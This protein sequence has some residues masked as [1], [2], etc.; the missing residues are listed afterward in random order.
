[1]PLIQAYLAQL[2]IH[3]VLRAQV[4]GAL[5]TSHQL[6]S[7]VISEAQATHQVANSL[8]HSMEEA[9]Q[10][11]LNVLSRVGQAIDS[12]D[13]LEKEVLEERMRRLEQASVSSR[14]M[15]SEQRRLERLGGKA[16]DLGIRIRIVAMNTSIEAMRAAS[17][18]NSAIGVLAREIGNLAI[19]VQ[20]LGLELS[21]SVQTLSQHLHREL[22]EGMA[23][24][25]QAIED[26][27]T[28][29]A[30]QVAA[31]RVSH[32]ELRQF[33]ES[34][35][36]Q[37]ADTGRQVTTHAYNTLGGVQN[38]DILRQ[39]LEQVV[40]VLVRMSEHDL[41]LRQA[42]RGEAALP[43]EWR[44]LSPSD[45]GRDYVMDA[46]RNAHREA[47]GQTGGDGDGALPTIE[48]F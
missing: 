12:A 38:Q 29:L 35:L 27:R 24:E 36:R 4:E 48:L 7:T 45:L 6:A 42:L 30:E 3:G 37:V 32:D 21:D 23:K 5:E 47:Q 44:P 16:H 14:H 10:A 33:R 34:A 28:R 40:T 17:S 2:D 15:V 18:T 1:M 19:E 46:Q 13:V 25:A 43:P 39:R 9:S 11:A 41:A 20:K 26:V 31:L 22:V 8:V